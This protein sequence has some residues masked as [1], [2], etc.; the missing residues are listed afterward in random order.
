MLITTRYK[1][2]QRQVIAEL[3]AKTSEIDSLKSAMADMGKMVHQLRRTNSI[4]A[5]L[6]SR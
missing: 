2:A 1:H 4:T 6:P 5:S 3:Q